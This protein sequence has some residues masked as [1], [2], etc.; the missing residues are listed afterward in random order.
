MALSWIEAKAKILQIRL[1]RDICSLFPQTTEI[2]VA[3]TYLEVSPITTQ[4]VFV[5]SISAVW[6][7]RLQISLVSR[8]CEIYAF[9]CTLGYLIN[10]QHVLLIFQKIPTFMVLLHPA[11][12]I[13]FGIFSS[14]HVLM[15]RL[16]KGQHPGG[17]NV[18]ISSFLIYP[19]NS[20]GAKHS[21]NRWFSKSRG[22]KCPPCPP[23]Y[24]GAVMHPAHGFI[25]QFIAL[26]IGSLTLKIKIIRKWSLNPNV[27]GHYIFWM[28]PLH[29][30]FSQFS[31]DM[32]ACMFITS[33]MFYW[34][35]E[36]CKPAC[37]LHPAWLL[38]TIE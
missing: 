13:N 36:N 21:N 2:L 19:Q 6:G 12:F 4:Y 26:F 9:A 23:C 35:W 31:N 18:L 24:A 1:T 7:K 17:A 16:R 29:V 15:Q 22:G 30:A 11:H 10:V 34:F 20:G 37:L 38:D 33:C 5:S 32:Q 25:F 8:I 27:K 14:L 3:K 28:A